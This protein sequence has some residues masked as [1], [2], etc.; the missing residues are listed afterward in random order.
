MYTE[1][2][3]LFENK[4][5]CCG[6]G[7]CYNIC[8]KNAIS[9]EADEHGYVYPVIDETKCVK[10][11]LCK[12]VCH[13]QNNDNMQKPIKAYAAAIKNDEEIM[14]AASGGIFTV[15]A[16]QILSESGVVFGVSME[17]VS[18]KLTPMHIDIQN[19]KELYKLQGSKYVQSDIGMTYK[20]V[21]EYL[22]E[23]RNVLFSGTPCQ[24]SGL[25][26]YLGK[27]YP[28]LLTVDVICHGVPSARLFQDY[29]KNQ[30]KKLGGRIYSYKFRDK[31][32]GQ[33]MNAQIL[34]KTQDN[35]EKVKYVDGYLTSYF[36]MFLKSIIYRENCY[37]CPYAKAERVSDIT[38]G[39]Y[40]GV[41]QVHEEEM[42]KSSMSNLKGVSCMIINTEK[43]EKYFGKVQDK[44]D[45][46]ETTVKKIAKNNKQLR[47]PSKCTDEREKVLNIYQEK[48]YEGVEEYFPKIIGYKRYFYIL[49]NL[50]PKGL[51]RRIKQ[52]ISKIRK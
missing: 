9:M 36:Y 52:V 17:N 46:F 1:R 25:N 7:A 45:F 37:S 18:G 35:K 40:W 27:D 23:G 14:V 31:S 29:I 3:I 43:G 2:I 16:K 51:K 21:K 5:D 19:E 22:M 48:G 41:Y 42:K 34:Y 44:L 8:P 26:S 47:E 50:A 30:E 13:F 20:K 10:C 6:C 39:D 38:A 4:K 15:L 49:K 12:K 24:I 33:G 32:K 11:G 28:N